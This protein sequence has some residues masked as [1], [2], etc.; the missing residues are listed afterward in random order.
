MR[1]IVELWRSLPL[2]AVWGFTLL[3]IGAAAL[4]ISIWDEPRQAPEP[5]GRDFP[6]NPGARDEGDISANN[7]PA[8]ARNPRTAGNLVVANRVDSPQYGCGLHVSFDDGRRWSDTRVPIPKR[9]EPKC[10]A[11]DVSFAVDGTM[12]MSFVTL[13]GRGNVPH[14]GWIVRSQD[15][16]RTLSKPVRVLGPFSFQVRLV[17]DPTKPGR[18]YL[19]WLQASSTGLYRFSEPGNPI[20]FARSDD[21]GTTWRRPVRVSNPVRARALA[22][23]PAVGRDGELYVLYLDLGEDR[24]DY[25]GLH[26]GRGG[27]PYRG[28]FS[29]VLARSRDGGATW[30]ESVADDRLVPTERFLAFL[31]PFPSIA[32]DPDSGQVYAGFHDGRLGDADAWVWSLRPGGGNWEGPVRVNDT[33]ERDQTS[34]YLPRLA[35]APDGRL[36]VVY[37]DRRADPR[38]LMNEVSLQSSDDGGKSFGERA[39]LSSQPFDSRIGAGSERRMPDLGN[40]LAM[41]SG[42]SEAFAVWSDTRAGTVASNKQDIAGARVT[43]RERGPRGAAR[44]GL[45][46]GGLGIALVGIS[47]LASSLRLRA[48]RA[49]RGAG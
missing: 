11:P 48:M 37:Y 14:A 19:T 25:E 42:D 32:V 3:L 30:D 47:L 2:R 12:Y 13:R 5:A 20:R 23:A 29:L 35:V 41:L 49:R 21:G 6:V 15:G 44:F 4:A 40:R 1:R 9:E 10:F 45:R 7:S 34:Q 22:P 16:G 24:L 43:F 18:L 39:L 17:A 31:P 33:P 8:L 26:G 46:Y 27:P 28:R 36:D 38:N